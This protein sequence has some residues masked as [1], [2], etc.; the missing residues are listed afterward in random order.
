ML[1]VA[2]RREERGLIKTRTA[3]ETSHSLNPTAYLNSD[4]SIPRPLTQ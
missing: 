4:G 1:N 3:S 2:K